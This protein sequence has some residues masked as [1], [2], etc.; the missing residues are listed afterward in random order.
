VEEPDDHLLAGL[1]PSSTTLCSDD[2]SVGPVAVKSGPAGLWSQLLSRHR[3]PSSARRLSIRARA[4]GHKGG[5]ERERL[6]GVAW[7]VVEH[8]NADVF[9]ELM[10]YMGQ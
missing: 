2:S 6:A 4:Q 3:H 10:A 9:D 1:S 5:E 7:H 8:I